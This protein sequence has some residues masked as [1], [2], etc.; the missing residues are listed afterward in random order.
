MLDVLVEDARA[1]G[2]RNVKTW[3]GDARDLDLPPRS[4]D[5]AISFNCI[6]FIPSPATALR[7]VRAALKPGARLGAI[8]FAAAARSF[9]GQL[10]STIRRAGGLPPPAPN[11]PGIFA[12]GAPGRFE[13]VLREAGFGNVD[14]QEVDFIRVFESRDEYLRNL[15]TPN[16]RSLLDQLDPA[17]RAAAVAAAEALADELTL[18]DGR[19]R[20]SSTSVLAIAAS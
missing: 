6:Q 10:A 20:G 7:R 11:E 3:P 8:V 1:A 4:F 14:V 15:E 5:A 12:L 19:I 18:P 17:R 13:A 9:Y 16:F 2:L